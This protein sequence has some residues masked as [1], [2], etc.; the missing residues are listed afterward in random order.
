MNQHAL[1]QI[2]RLMCEKVACNAKKIGGDLR[3][4]PAREDGEYFAPP[5]DQ[6]IK[7]EHIFC[8][9]QSFFTGM[10]LLSAQHTGDMELIRWCSSFYEDYRRKVFE[11]PQDTMH[12]LGFLYTL[13]STL[14]WKLTKSPEMRAL[15]LQAAEVLSHRFVPQGGY[16]RAWGRMDGTIPS[17]VGQQLAKDNFFANSDGLAII[18]C[19]MNLPLLFWAG[20]ETGDPFFTSV[21]MAHADT[22]LRYFVRDDGSV[23]HAYRFPTGTDAQPEE[24]ND[25]GYAVGSHWARGTAWAVYGFAAAWRYTKQTRYRDA[26]L[27]IANAY[28]KAC[29]DSV[30]PVWDFKLPENQPARYGGKEQ[31]WTKWDITDPEC[32]Q[33][34]VDSS[35][36]A[37]MAC[38]FLEILEQ[39]EHPRLRAYVDQTLHTLTQHY[40]DLNPDFPGLLRRVNGLDTYGC[41]GDYFAMELV[42][43]CLGK[44]L[45]IW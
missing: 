26:A 38:G 15:S 28:L 3:E 13:Y 14:H 22:T 30:I 44:K 36:A 29:G 39:E 23:C 27:K 7:T 20:Q 9:T 18:D 5:R 11:T 2:Y 24:Y 8:W 41:F 43:R 45:T 33:Y 34:N 6:L 35:A 31:P 1:E 25:C 17:Y 19:M 37:I 10:A 4:F 42:A 21:A 40:F 12:D 16:I 32:C